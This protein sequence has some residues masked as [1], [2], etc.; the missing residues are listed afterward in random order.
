MTIFLNHLHSTAA[1]LSLVTTI[2]WT[3]GCLGGPSG[4]TGTRRLLFIT[5]Q[6][7]TGLTAVSGLITTFTGPWTAMLFPYLGLVT[8]AG[9]GFAGGMAK[10]SLAMGDRRKALFA[11]VSQT[12]FLLAAAGLMAAKPF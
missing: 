11:A 2:A 10:R 6:A 4:M 9:H 12:A 7:T 8:V 3:A 1:A 5:V